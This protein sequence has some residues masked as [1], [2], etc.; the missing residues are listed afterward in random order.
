MQ[1]DPDQVKLPNLE[2]FV[3]TASSSKHRWRMRAYARIKWLMW[4][5]TVSAAYTIKRTIDIVG[6]V[7]GL[8]ILSPLFAVI[9]LWVK[10]DG[11]P[12]FFPQTRVGLHGR[13]FKMLKFRSMC[14]D[15][16][17]KLKELLKYNEKSEGVTFKMKDDPRITAVGKFIRK[18]SID[19]LPQLW[20][21][22]KGE[23]SLV[24]PRPPTVREVE[25][26]EQEDRRRFA[27][28][29]GITCLWQVGERQGGVW[30][31]GD[32]NSID[33]KEQVALDVR[34]IQSQS[35]WKDLW[36][37]IKTIPAIIFGKGV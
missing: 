3:Q 9:I 19:E 31:I 18:S 8:I 14:V 27:V 29:P 10:K 23:M 28:K 30:E 26:Y 6:S 7:F 1:D 24:G 11:G 21:V 34:Y 13:Q 5:T 35:I 22:V 17:A 15:A 32:R 33:F 4:R 20:N 37:L 36:I 16:E 12:A 2:R 25:L